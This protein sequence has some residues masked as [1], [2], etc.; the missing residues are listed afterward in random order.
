METAKCAVSFFTESYSRR[1]LH[2]LEVYRT[3]ELAELSKTRIT[4]RLDNQYEKPSER[5][6]NE[7]RKRVVPLY[8]DEFRIVDEARTSLE[9]PNDYGAWNSPF[10]AETR[11]IEQL[12]R[13]S[14]APIIKSNQ[15]R[16]KDEDLSPYEIENR[17][18]NL[19]SHS[20]STNP[21]YETIYVSRNI[22]WV[23]M[24]GTAF[25]AV[26]TGVLI[27]YLIINMFSGKTTTQEKS[28][29]SNDTTAAA[30]VD[31]KASSV[32]AP[33]T[34]LQNASSAI[35]IPSRS[36]TF[37]QNGGFSTVERADQ[38][39]SEL[40]QQGM[41]AVVESGD[42]YFVYV[43][44]AADRKAAL[45]LSE[46]LKAKNMEI[47]MKPYVLPAVQNIQWKGNT[48]FLQTYSE[49]A[50]QLVQ[51]LSGIT[52]VHLE[53]A[54]LTTIAATTLQSIQS[55][56]EAWTQTSSQVFAD[57]SAN[58][59]PTL[60]KMTNVMNTAKRSMDEYKK[61]P[62]YEMLW[63]AQTNIIQFI[64]AEKTLLNELVIA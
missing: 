10:D 28:A 19:D 39:G 38:V 16:A 52:L 12:I 57:A 17:F 33:I 40:H 15:M 61:S 31:S 35:Q 8:E 22:P 11:R 60:Q 44:M 62:T 1:C 32:M 24:L 36:Y 46:Q 37:L 50:D 41:T 13:E 56:F 58:V 6:S 29:I 55:S 51:M 14:N 49:Q 27:G 59:K 4:Y 34:S 43:G 23:K 63:Q 7:E 64:I 9:Y 20:K 2:S 48:E 45:N 5:I 26:V 53:E 30:E 21:S 54:Q 25:G 18:R 47:Y 42:K 3:R